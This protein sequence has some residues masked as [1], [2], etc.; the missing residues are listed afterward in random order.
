MLALF[1]ERNFRKEK[2]LYFIGKLETSS[3]FYGFQA[4]HLIDLYVCELFLRLN[5]GK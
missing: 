1:N 3:H 2:Y 4:L 5:D